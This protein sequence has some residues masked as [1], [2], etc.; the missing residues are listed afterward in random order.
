MMARSA[1]RSNQRP[2]TLMQDRYRRIDEIL[3]RRTAGP[4][5][6]SFVTFWACPAYVRLAPDSDRR[7]DIPALPF[8][9]NNCHRPALLDHRVGASKVSGLEHA[10][11]STMLASKIIRGEHRAG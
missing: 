4:Y 10:P 6:G 11:H 3:L 8:S 2:D 9:A 7:A 1:K 5:I